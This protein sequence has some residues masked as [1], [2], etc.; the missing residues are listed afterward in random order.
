MSI[1]KVI[2][3]DG[4]SD[5]WIQETREIKIINDLWNDNN[6]KVLNKIFYARLVLLNKV[7]PDIPNEEE[8][9]PI[10]ILSPL[11]KYLDIRFNEKL[12]NK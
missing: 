5:T 6:L 10:V 12:Q 4:I 2:T 3:L 1:N 9:K 11:F 8:F 7:W